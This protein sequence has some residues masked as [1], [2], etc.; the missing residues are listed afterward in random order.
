M[1]GR[2]AMLLVLG[3]DAQLAARPATPVQLTHAALRAGFDAAIPASW[4]DELVADACSR[5]V[6]AHGSRPWVFCACPFVAQRV[7][8][9]GTDLAPFLASFVA[10]PAALARYIRSFYEPGGVRLTYVG[11]CP[12][13]FGDSY[14]A[15]VAPAEFLRLLADRDIDPSTQPDVFEAVIPPDRRRHHSLPGGLPAITALRGVGAPHGIV[16]LGDGDLSTEIAQQLL[17]GVPVLLDGAERLGCACA[18][19]GAADAHDARTAV[20]ALEPPRAFAPV[21]ELPPALDLSLPLPRASREATDLIAAAAR[22]RIGGGVPGAGGEP[23]AVEDPPIIGDRE[24]ARDVGLGDDAAQPPRRRSPS[25]GVPV[26]RPPAGFSPI[27][28][29]TDGR[30]LPRAYVARRRSGP[31]PSIDDTASEQEPR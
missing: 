10:P 21:L 26:V 4:G 31:R 15:V 24:V 27:A 7:L 1:P 23:R 18:G 30:V 16:E 3:N 20:I 17:S 2:P 8:D 13:A 22:A 12:G 19:A 6:A 11:R 14:D 25:N 5:Q 28:R 9:A 29:G